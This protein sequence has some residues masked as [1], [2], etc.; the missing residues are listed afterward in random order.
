[1]PR[2]QYKSMASVLQKN[3]C[4]RCNQAAA[5]IVKDRSDETYGISVTINDCYMTGVAPHRH[6]RWTNPRCGTLG[7]DICTQACQVTCIE[8]TMPI[9]IKIGI[10]DQPVSVANRWTANLDCNMETI[11]AEGLEARH[12][13]PGEKPK[14][15]Q[16]G[17]PLPVWRALEDFMSTIENTDR[18]HIV[19]RMGSKVG[20]RVKPAE[21][22]QMPD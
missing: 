11:D 12:V 10:P 6:Q 16:S 3:A 22:D 20:K 9:D 4:G 5:K 15:H 21:R 2:R 8:H 19:S 17:N 1:M 13:E 7:V 14:H 18:V